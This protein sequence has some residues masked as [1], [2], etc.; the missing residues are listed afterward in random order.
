MAENGSIVFMGTP[1]FAATILQAL[2][3]NGENVI[4]VY[5]Q[6]DKAAGR[7]LEPKE[8]AVKT[9]ALAHQLP[10]YQPPNFRDEYALGQLAQL[11]PDFLVVAAYGLILPEVVLEMPLIAPL[12]IHG[13]L[14]PLY[15]GAAPIQRA[16]MENWGPESISGVSLMKIIKKMDAGPVYGSHAVPIRDHTWGSLSGELAR[17]GAQLL[18]DLLPGIRAGEVRAIPQN[19][20]FATYAP[21]LAKE[22]GIIRWNRP[23]LA[24]DAQIRGV[25]P[26]PGARTTIRLNDR[27]IAITILAGEI[28]SLAGEPAGTVKFGKGSLRIAC[29][30]YWYMPTEIKP[31]GRKSMP[32]ADFVNGLQAGPE[33]AA[34]CV[35]AAIIK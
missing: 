9:L 32:S 35:D 30:D 15:R 7:K 31:E 22:E 2:L 16:V 13:S 5:T 11:G 8:S 33:T 18:L 21:K 23:A 34:A 14:L 10:L 27:A 3:D 29:E 17:V 26:W 6:P 12:N 28:G 20:E 4:A 24:V 19:E 1:P 25:T